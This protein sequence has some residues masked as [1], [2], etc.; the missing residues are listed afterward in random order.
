[1]NIKCYVSDGL[2]YS[3]YEKYIET[4]YSKNQNNK[5]LIIKVIAMINEKMK[6]IKRCINLECL[7]RKTKNLPPN[8]YSEIRLVKDNKTLI[9]I[10][11]FY[12]EEI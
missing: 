10:I 7:K 4:F 8:P 6:D 9:R 11:L 2:K 3:P 12:E 1:M 5:N